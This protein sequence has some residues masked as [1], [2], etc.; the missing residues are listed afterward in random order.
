MPQKNH[1]QRRLIAPLLLFTLAGWALWA[2]GRN[3]RKAGPMSQTVSDRGHEKAAST[4]TRARAKWSRRRLATSLAFVTL[5]FAGAAFS[6]GA[7][8]VVASALEG[9]TSSEETSTEADPSD[10]AVQPAEEQPAEE[11]PAEEQPAEEQPA[12]DQPT[13]D[14]PTDGDQ[15]SGQNGQAGE[16]SDD[17]GSGEGTSDSGNPAGDPADSDDQ[18]AGGGEGE[19]PSSGDDQASGGADD[20][21]APNPDEG[22]G[23]NSESGSDEGPP[24]MGDGR[25]GPTQLDPEADAE[26]FFAT[27]WL[28]RTMPDPTPPAKRLSPLF[29]KTLVREAARDRVDWALLLGVLRAGGFDGR[30]MSAV[31]V[32][33]TADRLVSLGVRRNAWR[34]LLAFHGRTAFADRAL[35]LARYN[36]AAGLHA[37][38]TGLTA[39]KP[40][41]QRKVLADRR[42]HIYQG[43]RLDVALGRIDVRVLVLME[44]LAEAHGEVT[45]SSLLSGHRLYARPGVV[46]AHIYG[47]AVDVSGLGGSSIAGNQ[48]PNGLTERAVRHILL[49]PKE[50]QPRQVISL[51]GLGGPSFPL[52]DHWD[53]I[54][55]GY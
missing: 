13:E 42:L 49:L 16:P 41:L 10:E 46:S 14:Q 50:L 17:G 38:V 27:V 23:E 12:E 45:V 32:R 11:Q 30:S 26:G 37:L 24:L 48:Q 28:H 40:S 51:L 4:P 36:R 18:P 8:D 39:A 3:E 20:A 52:A 15:G 31:G 44:Y 25:D 7:G 9:T 35:A 55:I 6:A 47:L 43:G 33:R 53:H 21:P 34:A 2:L 1:S 5:F 29:A 54:H 19:Q 22:D